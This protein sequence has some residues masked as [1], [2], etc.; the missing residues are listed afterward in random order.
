MT[1]IGIPGPNMNDEAVT[2][3]SVT[4]N[5]FIGVV[6]PEQERKLQPE[7]NVALQ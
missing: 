3:K 1:V 6:C 5:L 2:F 4:L 7:P